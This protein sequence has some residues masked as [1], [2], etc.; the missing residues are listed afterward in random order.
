MR[1]P[2]SFV[3]HAQ[4][5]ATNLIELVDVFLADSLRSG[6]SYQR[7]EPLPD[8]TS[9]TMNSNCAHAEIARPMAA[10]WSTVA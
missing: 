6:E 3:R 7:I 1:Y 4:G 10:A 8:V 2:V 9:S 5:V